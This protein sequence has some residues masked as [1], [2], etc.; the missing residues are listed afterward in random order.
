MSIDDLPAE[1]LNRLSKSR[2]DRI[3]EKHEGPE[4]WEWQLK[5]H[6]YVP[7]D[8]IYQIEPDYDP[9]LAR[10]EFLQ[11]DNQWVLLPVGRKH[12]PNMTILHC[13]LSEDRSKLVV[14]L[15][16]TTFYDD[17]SMSGFIGIC[18]RQREGFYLAS[19][20]HDWFIIDYDAEVKTRWI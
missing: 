11:I 2:W 6:E 18:D 19:L 1:T 8:I 4:T 9:V 13:F 5:P 14:Y 20:L 15:K 10:P 3:I 16:D 12:H 7:D 17:W